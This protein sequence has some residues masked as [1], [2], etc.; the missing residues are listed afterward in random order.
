MDLPGAIATS[1]RERDLV[2]NRERPGR[3][4]RASIE[5]QPW[6]PGFMR[7]SLDQFCSDLAESGFLTPA[8]IREVIESLPAERKPR[9]APELIRELVRLHK[10]TIYQAQQIYQGNA[11][12]LQ[13]GNYTVLDKIGQGGMGVVLKAEHRRM[14]RVVALKVIRPREFE[15]PSA[16]KRFHREV[17]TA[18]QLIHPNIVTAF[19]ADEAQ[20]THFLVMEYVDGTDLSTL[21]KINGPL[22]VA[23]AMLCICQAAR[24]L[25]YAHGKGI[26]HR[27]IK[28]RNLLLDR[29]GNV[30]ILDMGLARVE[31]SSGL[32]QADL[33]GSGQIM[34][35]ID[36]MAPE[37]AVNPKHADQRADIY[38]LGITLW[39]L[40]TGKLPFTGETVLEKLVAHREQPIPSLSAARRGVA[41][42]LDAIFRRMVGKKPHQRYASMVDLLADLEACPVDAQPSVPISSRP[43]PESELAEFLKGI[44]SAGGGHDRADTHAGPPRPRNV[45]LTSETVAD[46]WSGD[47]TDFTFSPVAP[48][49][50]PAAAPVKPDPEPAS[51]PPAP[52]ALAVPPSTLAALPAEQAPPPTP[53]PLPAPTPPTPS[54]AG[55]RPKRRRIAVPIAWGLAAAVIAAIALSLWALQV[56]NSPRPAPRRSGQKSTAW[57]DSHPGRPIRGA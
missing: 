11:R 38:S 4:D 41:R 20:G 14:R 23:T 46:G 21:V 42:E 15:S 18:A 5:Q 17:E 37:Q 53:R 28:P 50:A 48:T 43:A 34:G 25:D 9:E 12:R 51:A 1:L 45:P 31:T 10:L 47:D 2:P 6:R 35:T 26:I 40:L 19:D 33:T 3:T 52:P 27:D 36:Y 32:D 57:H 13:L 44:S 16:L 30:K 8:D 39:Y 29:K 24:G 56:G 22:P 54:P 55:P 49:P 7:P